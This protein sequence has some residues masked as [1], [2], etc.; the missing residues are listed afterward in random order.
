MKRLLQGGSAVNNIYKLLLVSI[1]AVGGVD[2]VSAAE[3]S[4]VVSDPVIA[5]P[6]WT[7]PGAWRT[8]IEQ[9]FDPAT[10]TLM[11]RLYTFWDA[12]P[13]RDFDFIWTP[14]NPATD[15]P[16]KINGDGLLVWRFK[17][18]PSYDPDSVF[19]QYRG[20]VRDGRMEGHGAYLDHAGL[21]YEGEWQAGLPDGRGSL[22]LA[23]G[24]EYAGQ[25]RRGKANGKG[26]YIDVT[27]E[28]YEGP[29]VD[30]RRHGRGTTTLP[31][32]NSYSSFWTNGV[33]GGASH[34]TRIAL[35]PGARVPGGADD[36]RI[37]ITLDQRLP[38]ST[39]AEERADKENFD[40]WYKVSNA[41]S[42]L[43]IR[44]AKP[45]LMS[46]WK[47]GGE[48]QLS[49][50][51]E[52]QN[53]EA[54]GVVSLVR[55]QIIPLNLNVE[56]Q[57]RSANQI[58]I[59]GVYIDVESS[60]TDRQPA[61]QM[62]KESAFR[63]FS[64]TST[65]PDTDTADEHYYDPTYFLENFGWGSAQGAQLH[66][67]FVKAS[68]TT[69]P[70]ALP[71]TH[72]IGTIERSVKVDFEPYLRAAGVDINVLNRNSAKGFV[73]KVK[74]RAGCLNQIKSTGAFGSLTDLLFL[75]GIEIVVRT[76]G[77]L[78]Y[79]WIDIAGVEH[80]A[81]SPF[82][83]ELALGGLKR[84]AE[85]G[86][87]GAREMI[88]RK[89]Q[90]LRLDASGYRI[91]IAFSTAVPGGRTARLILPIEAEKSSKH[92]FK[93]VVQLADGREISSRPI[94][95]L[96]YRPRWFADY[97]QY[98]TG[99]ELYLPNYSL[100]GEDLQ[101][102]NDSNTVQCEE[103]CNAQSRCRAFTFDSWTSACFLKGSVTMM[104][105]DPRNTSTLKEGTPKPTVS[106]VPKILN[107][108]SNKAFPGY[109]YLIAEQSDADDCEKRCTGDDLCVALTFKR[110]QRD[111]YLFKQVDIYSATPDA[112]SAM[113]SQPAK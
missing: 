107:R 108:Y 16:G 3:R 66:F 81:S 67:A 15:K 88:T 19:A 109:G 84:E 56:V 100:A 87:G 64:H 28:I 90:Q 89:T 2:A 41:D 36:I 31:N 104:R 1:L 50:N 20:T 40:L 34:F 44:P 101:V 86:E 11:R 33:E 8:E 65:N 102:I 75:D 21:L 59:S 29:F 70:A 58:Q 5:G 92:D 7:G 111:C 68:T 83:V 47:E 79:G 37:A 12:D 110:T 30:G 38:P 48:I 10:H 35:G 72:R 99:D 54:F 9:V 91:P 63:D 42:G 97:N 78:D 98:P 80:N 61:I 113:K 55:E 93:I 18:R 60:V 112:D 49:R 73:C 57:N 95:L 53:S 4:D 26:R 24:D 22:R 82:N 45:R 39:H 76:F 105:L 69:K 17:N 85:Q 32:G 52:N 23:S 94:D 13:S 71:Q 77:T 27:G 14:D 74:D 46:M 96:Y 103:A 51:D 6:A 25:F 62:S 43:L 106:T